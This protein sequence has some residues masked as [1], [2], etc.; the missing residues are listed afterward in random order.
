MNSPR[1]GLKTLQIT[2]TGSTD[3][4]RKLKKAFQL[5]NILPELKIQPEDAL[6]EIY[7]N[8]FEVIHRSIS[9]NL[10]NHV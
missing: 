6:E 5:E 1:N 8:V 4:D 2:K 7:A 10:D 9:L 3:I